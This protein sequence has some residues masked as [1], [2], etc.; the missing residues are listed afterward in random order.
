MLA[1]IG[2]DT[3]LDDGYSPDIDPLYQK[4]VP[5]I[6]NLVKDTPD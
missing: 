5:M 1:P 4:G 2:A 6:R 3:Y